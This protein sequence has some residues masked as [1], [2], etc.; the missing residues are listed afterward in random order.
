ME[1]D[2]LGAARN[3]VGGISA[4]PARHL[5]RPGP[6]V[7][8]RDIAGDDH[9]FEALIGPRRQLWDRDDGKTSNSA[10]PRGRAVEGLQAESVVV[11]CFEVLGMIEQM[12]CSFRFAYNPN[13]RVAGQKV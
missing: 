12:V 10:V 11:S 3:V 4:R 5:G 9:H 6:A 2:E 1:E 13:L 8:G 7:R